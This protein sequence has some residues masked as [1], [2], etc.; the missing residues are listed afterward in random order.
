VACSF[1]DRGA[2]TFAGAAL[3]TLRTRLRF[4][5]VRNVTFGGL[6][7]ESTLAMRTLWLQHT[8]LESMVISVLKKAGHT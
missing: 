5:A 6:F 4:G 1:A 7:G 8:R 3:Q 2:D